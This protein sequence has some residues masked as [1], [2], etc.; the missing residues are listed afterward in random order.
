M[1]DTVQFFRHHADVHY[2]VD[3]KI[4]LSSEEEFEDFHQRMNRLLHNVVRR[5]PEEEQFMPWA[6]KKTHD[7]VV[8]EFL[9]GTRLL[10]GKCWYDLSRGD[11]SMF[12]EN[13]LGFMPDTLQNMMRI[14]SLAPDCMRQLWDNHCAYDLEIPFY[15]VTIV[16]DE[17]PTKHNKL[18]TL[19]E[20][21]DD[22]IIGLIAHAISQMSYPWR[23][24]Q[25][26]MGLL[27]SHTEDSV[28]GEARRLGFR[29]EI[30]ALERG[31]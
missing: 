4:M 9:I 19:P 7:S 6:N 3:K 29:K 26:M 23:E 12:M 18:Q 24:R 10:L 22:Y 1:V 21:S 31:I 14:S 8:A 30:D 16:T 13:G 20:K 27:D 15:A 5:L 11:T 25:V 28:M 17:T 2:A